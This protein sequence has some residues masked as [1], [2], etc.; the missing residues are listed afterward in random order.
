M[1]TVRIEKAV[2]TFLT[3]LSLTVVAFDS[4]HAQW[5]PPRGEGSFSI[6]YQY[7]TTGQHLWSE[8]SGARG[9]PLA[10]WGPDDTKVT[11]Y[12]V[13]MSLDYA[14]YDRIAVN[15]SL[16]FIH[17]EFSGS[18]LYAE[19]SSSHRI[20]VA[21]NNA[22]QDLG[23]DFRYMALTEPLFVTTSIGLN[24][25]THEYGTHGH[26]AIGKNLKTFRVGASVGRMLDPVVPGVYL[27]G[28]YSYHFS[29]K[30]RGINL[31]RSNAS[32]GITYFAPI[33]SLSLSAYWNHQ[34][35]HGGIDSSDLDFPTNDMFDVH[36]RIATENFGQLGGVISYAW[37]HWLSIYAG[38][39]RIIDRVSENSQRSRG[40]NIGTITYF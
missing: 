1:N 29:E 23:V 14:V 9:Y 4:A 26:S 37:T 5:V 22:F 2:A 15:L 33:R 36:D 18:W 13:V 32:V 20:D 27:Q 34:I 19:G 40:I 10:E 39:F 35:T 8:L 16:P 3:A 11:G 28:S 12:I 25:P 30:V 24:W 31:N 6:E 21:P 38:A 17:T 7:F